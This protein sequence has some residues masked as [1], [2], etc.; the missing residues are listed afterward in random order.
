V[1]GAGHDLNFKKGKNS[2]GGT[3]APSIVAG[4]QEFFDK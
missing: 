1:I 4:F 3:L 2:E